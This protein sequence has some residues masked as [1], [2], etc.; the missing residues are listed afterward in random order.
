MTG[1]TQVAR[2]MLL[3]G[4]KAGQLFHL[5]AGRAR[6]N[7][8]DSRRSMRTMTSA[9]TAAQL[10]VR[11]L[12]LGAVAIRTGLERGQPRVRLMAIGASLVPLRRGLLFGAM[13]TAAG[14][15]KLARVRLVTADATRMALL[16]EPRF[17]LMTVIAPDFVRLGVMGQALVAVG[18]GLVAL[19]ERNLLDARRVAALARCDVAQRELE[20]VRFVA[21]RAGRLRVRAVIGGRDLVARRACANVHRLGG[22]GRL[23]MRIVAT[24]A[25]PAALRVVRMNVLVTGRARRSRRRQDVMRSMA[26]GAAVV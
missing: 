22:A 4:V 18:A 16:D 7:A 19:V 13:T 1:V 11:A 14:G 24:H 10:A 9:T 20:T 17:A 12:L 25:V 2:P 15:R 21:A 23:R 6:R 3:L 5:M 26:V 8:R